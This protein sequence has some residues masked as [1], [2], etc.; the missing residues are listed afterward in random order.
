MDS[1]PRAL[2]WVAGILGLA[3]VAVDHQQQQAKIEVA[4]IEAGGEMTWRNECELPEEDE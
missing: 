2:V 1:L 4:C 3:W